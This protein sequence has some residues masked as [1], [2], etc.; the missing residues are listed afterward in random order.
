MCVPAE[1]VRAL[2][3]RLRARLEQSLSL[4]LNT[5]R[6]YASRSRRS[7][8]RSRSTGSY[9]RQRS[10]SASYERSK[11]CPEYIENHTNTY[12]ITENEKE[13]IFKLDL[14]H[15]PAL[16][17]NQPKRLLPAIAYHHRAISTEFAGID[18]QH[19][20]SFDKLCLRTLK[21][22]KIRK[23]PQIPHLT[24]TKF[25]YLSDND[26]DNVEN[27]RDA[28]K[29]T[30][31]S[32]VDLIPKHYDATQYHGYDSDGSEA[33]TTIHISIDKQVSDGVR[34]K[35]ESSKQCSLDNNK[36][37]DVD[38]E[39]K[40]ETNNNNFKSENGCTTNKKKP[41]FNTRKN[42]L[43]L[44][45]KASYEGRPQYSR[46]SLDL[47]GSKQRDK[48]YPDKMEEKPLLSNKFHDSLRRR[49]SDISEVLKRLNSI[50]EGHIT[51]NESIFK[52]VSRKYSCGHQSND[53][54]VEGLAVAKTAKKQEKVVSISDVSTYQQNRLYHSTPSSSPSV[55]LSFK[56][57]LPS[58][59]KTA[60]PRSYSVATTG[61]LDREVCII[62]K[63][64]SVA[65]SPPNP[66][67]PRRAHSPV[68][69]PTPPAAPASSTDRR[70][71]AAGPTAATNLCQSTVEPTGDNMSHR[72]QPITESTSATGTHRESSDGQQ[73]TS[74]DP[75]VA[76][77]INKRQSISDSTPRAE[78]QTLQSMANKNRNP[79]NKKPTE[80]HGKKSV[81]NAPRRT[82]KRSNE[83]GGRDNGRGNHHQRE[84]QPLERRESRRGQFT[85]SLSN[86]DVPPNDKAGMSLITVC[87]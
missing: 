72:E 4:P 15:Y 16:P 36:H 80:K 30:Q 21:Q 74:T 77:A 56:E 52:T 13:Y 17:V 67:S 49:H 3:S 57:P 14:N 64:M 12:K 26:F 65:L 59:I 37:E 61:R 60:R 40:Y 9:P 79:R 35:S 11:S 44:D 45:L 42:C 39:I 71:S 41:S 34:L 53:L 22:T 76:N 51:P 58:I 47:S 33:E 48:D 55:E 1:A 31:I 66:G 87:Y 24:R 28:D 18:T 27:L 10:H 23:L 20:T 50:E 54:V 5:H 63:R 83:Y 19:S 62:A 25:C 32:E 29:N 38:K 2:R 6:T 69:P 73:S 70:Q 78:F 46:F 86:A 81:K 84:P 68:A 75:N 7:V 43:S 8:A 85:R 82:S